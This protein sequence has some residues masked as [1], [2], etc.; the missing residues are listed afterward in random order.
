[1][2]SG[3]RIPGPLQRAAAVAD[4]GRGVAMHAARCAALDDE[5]PAA[6]G[7]PVALGGRVRLGTRQ[8]GHAGAHFSPVRIMPL[9]GAGPAP[10][11]LR[12]LVAPST[13]LIAAPRFW[14]PASFT[15]V[16]P[17]VYAWARFP[18]WVFTGIGP[19]RPR[20]PSAA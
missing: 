8:P 9:V 10:P 15:C 5:F 11:A 3:V 2:E 19:P 12:G 13:W 17:C 4:L 1:A 14:R 7:E 6:G 20:F 16:I 18:P